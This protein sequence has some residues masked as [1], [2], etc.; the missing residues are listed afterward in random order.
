MTLGPKMT[1]NCA[2]LLGKSKVN[3]PSLTF[4]IR[5]SR[6]FKFQDIV[7]KRTFFLHFFCTNIQPKL[8]KP[9]KRAPQKT[10][11]MTVFMGFS[12]FGANISS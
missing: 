4:G 8:N 1:K 3:K 9:K 5:N 12:Q 11:Q 6:K 10:Y 2:Q 7:F